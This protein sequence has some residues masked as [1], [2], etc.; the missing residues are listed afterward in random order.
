LLPAAY[1]LIA[2]IV[3]NN[4]SNVTSANSAWS[5]I[6][7]QL[8]LET[9]NQDKAAIVYA[10][11]TPDTPPISLVTSLSQYGLDTAEGGTAWLFESIANVDSIGGQAVISTMR[12]AR[13]LQR[14]SE[15]GIG[16]DIIVSDAGVEPQATLS[17]GQ[18]S[19]TEAENQKI[20]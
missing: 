7:S 18:Y 11:L 6:A 5:N 12:E 15:A 9:T 3:A 17:S 13:N 14:L 8:V 16:T 10:D 4:S 20:I 19:V 2:N 1:S